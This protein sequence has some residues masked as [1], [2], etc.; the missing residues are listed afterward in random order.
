MAA[1][2]LYRLLVRQPQARNHHQRAKESTRFSH[3]RRRLT[4]VACLSQ[5][6]A[7]DNCQ[8]PEEALL[9]AAAASSSSMSQPVPPREAPPPRPGVIPAAQGFQ[10]VHT[11]LPA[12]LVS[13]LGGSS[14]GGWYT[15]RT[16]GRQAASSF[17][18]GGV[19]EASIER[20]HRRSSVG[21]AY[22]SGSALT[23][24]GV[25]NSGAGAGNSFGSVSGPMSFG[26]P[27][28]RPPSLDTGDYSSPRGHQGTET[29]N[30]EGYQMGMLRE[31]P[32]QQQQ[33]YA[34]YEALG[35]HALGISPSSPFGAG[36]PHRGAS[37]GRRAGGAS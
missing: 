36:R 1:A 6:D 22:P 20:P 2:A 24:R 17:P 33:G 13:K 37:Y 8:L 18:F 27:F 31:E 5:G 19:G 21:A 4:V 32:T 25:G 34:D 16:L 10:R 23:D 35:T 30:N 29:I 9:P 28:D 14:H 11:P 15:Q 26:R 7:F 12:S 3:N